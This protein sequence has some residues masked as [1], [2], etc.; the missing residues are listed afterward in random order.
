MEFR[1]HQSSI[2][3]FYFFIIFEIILYILLYN[4]LVVE[5]LFLLC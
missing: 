5:F 3:V 1:E 2:F 4:Y